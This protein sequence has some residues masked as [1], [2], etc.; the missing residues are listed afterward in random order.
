MNTT[1]TGQPV[2]KDSLK[3]ILQ[4][5]VWISWQ[6]GGGRKFGHRRQMQGKEE[7]KVKAFPGLNRTCRL[8]S[9]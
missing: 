1:V 4:W 3:R 7:K 2:E 5:T 9:C 8:E 6:F